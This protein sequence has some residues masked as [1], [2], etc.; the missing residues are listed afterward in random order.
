MVIISETIFCFPQ[1]AA[2]KVTGEISETALA[3]KAAV[4][5][6]MVHRKVARQTK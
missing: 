1:W 4:L 3:A 5:V 2:Q 6:E